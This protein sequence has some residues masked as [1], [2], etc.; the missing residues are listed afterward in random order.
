MTSRNSI[1]KSVVSMPSDNGTLIF[2]PNASGTPH[3][4]NALV[5]HLAAREAARRGCKLKARIDTSWELLKQGNEAEV[6]KDTMRGVTELADILEIQFAEIYLSWSEERKQRCWAV[7][8]W[9]IEQEHIHPAL[10]PL[11]Y[12]LEGPPVGE[13]MVRG[14]VGYNINKIWRN[15]FHGPSIELVNVVD[16]RDNHVPLHIRAVDCLASMAS[17]IGIMKL[18]G[19]T[20][21]LYAH[22][23]VITDADGNKLDKRNPEHDKYTF[24]KWAAQFNSAKEIRDALDGFVFAGEGRELTDI[25]K[26]DKVP[27]GWEG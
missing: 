5:C 15:D 1:Q 14:S 12:I 2:T 6:V 4:G 23:P 20:P 26:E 8:Q 13:D 22:I 19:Q 9:F 18:L 16:F 10:T 7:V 24:S 3:V 21:P 17:E 25:S 27:L 11:Y